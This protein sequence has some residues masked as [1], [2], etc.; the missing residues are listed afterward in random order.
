MK[1]AGSTASH[2]L[3]IVHDSRQSPPTFALFDPGNDSRW[4]RAERS[5]LVD[6][7]TAD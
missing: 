6:L 1:A 5:I 3:D 4:L 7:N 2:E